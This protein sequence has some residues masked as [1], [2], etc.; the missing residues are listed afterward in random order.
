MATFDSRLWIVPDRLSEVSVTVDVDA[1]RI[2]IT[3]GLIVIGDWS[4]SDVTIEYRDHDIHVF[5]EGE[6]LVVWSADPGFVDAMM[7]ADRNPLGDLGID[8]AE[9]RRRVQAARPKHLRRR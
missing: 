1:E 9:L 5:A 6:E 3:S 2:K 7:E 4:I 8:A